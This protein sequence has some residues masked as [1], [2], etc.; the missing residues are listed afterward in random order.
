MSYTVSERDCQRLEVSSRK[1]WLLTNGIGGFA[2][3]TVS[4][5]NTRRYHGLLVAAVDPPAGRQVL[6]AGRSE[7]HTSE[8]QSHSEISYAVFFLNMCLKVVA[9]PTRKGLIM[10][11]P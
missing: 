1:E 10:R 11:S 5:I 3:G 2:S 6:L 8:L 9:S 4:G 7:E